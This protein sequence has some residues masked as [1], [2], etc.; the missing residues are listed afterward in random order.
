MCWVSRGV[1]PPSPAVDDTEGAGEAVRLTI[2]L[3][4]APDVVDGIDR[5]YQHPEYVNASS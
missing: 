3:M 2:V 1:R 5:R 4:T